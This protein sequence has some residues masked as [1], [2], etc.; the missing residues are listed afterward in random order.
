MTGGVDQV[1][2]ETELVGAISLLGLL[3]LAEVEV[4]LQNLEV[5]GDSTEKG[6][7]K[8]GWI[9]IHEFEVKFF[10]CCKRFH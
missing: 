1:D 10:L 7:C 2:K 6:G 3:L 5:H 4:L 8:Y 9:L